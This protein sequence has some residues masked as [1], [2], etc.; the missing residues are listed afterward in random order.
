MYAKTVGPIL[1]CNPKWYCIDFQMLE[2][3]Q[4][5]IVPFR[6]YGHLTFTYLLYGHRVLRALEHVALLLNIVRCTTLG[7]G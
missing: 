7:S 3:L 1:K 2:E 6:R 4:H 5:Y